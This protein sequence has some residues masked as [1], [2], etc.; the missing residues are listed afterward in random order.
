[1]E[2]FS[3]ERRAMKVVDRPGLSLTGVDVVTAP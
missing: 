3:N 1:L 2:R